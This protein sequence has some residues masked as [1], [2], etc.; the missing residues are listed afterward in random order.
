MKKITMILAAM[1]AMAQMSAAPA[2]AASEAHATVAAAADDDDS[3]SAYKT[4]FANDE[5]ST[6]HWTVTTS[7]FYIGMGVKHNWDKVNNSF[8]VG[9]LN[10]AAV[11]YNTLHGQQLSLG[12]GIHHRS[13]S[14]K[15][16]HMLTR[17]NEG[18]VSLTDYP[19]NDVDEIK[20]RSSNLNVWAVQFPLMFSQK[21]YKKL[22]I[23][24][25]GIMNWNVNARADN[26]WELNKVETDS[27]HK[28]LKQQKV[29]F[30]LMGALSWNATGIYC[31]YSPGKFFKDG[32]GPEIKNTWTLGLTIGL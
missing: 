21:I 10:V 8:E 18:V 12:V 26:H 13:Y 15:R 24:V 31:R 32:Y 11:N 30:D 25:A 14:I 3:E 28:G 27:R 22:E 17:N 9:M 23:T 20:K 6:K 29:N 5:N 4:P 2:I 16:P 19:S 1:L 7:G